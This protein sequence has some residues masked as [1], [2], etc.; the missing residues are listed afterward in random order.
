MVLH[1]VKKTSILKIVATAEGKKIFLY[2]MGTKFVR[3]P[4]WIQGWDLVYT[5]KGVSF[6]R[7][8]SDRKSYPEVT[9][10]G[11]GCTFSQVFIIISYGMVRLECKNNNANSFHKLATILKY[12]RKTT[13]LLP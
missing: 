10:R 8:L 13:V 5:F 11:P 7:L 6:R 9:T 2:L 3:F 1:C 4:S 12:S